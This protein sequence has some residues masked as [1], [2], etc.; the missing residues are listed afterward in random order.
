[1]PV[2]GN[3]SPIISR[4]SFTCR[5]ITNNPL[6]A[7]HYGHDHR[8]SDKAVYSCTLHNRRW[9]T[10]RRKRTS[11]NPAATHLRIHPLPSQRIPLRHFAHPPILLR[12]P[13]RPL[14]ARRPLPGQTPYHALDEQPGMQ[15]LAERPL[16]KGRR[17]RLP[18][19]IQH[20]LAPRVLA[21]CA[22]LLRQRRR[23]QLPPHRPRREKTRVRALR[24][25][26]LSA[27]A[28]MREE[29]REEEDMHVLPGGVLSVREGV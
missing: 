13:R 9:T 12:L 21:L 17:V 29:A 2:P 7:Y 25:R 10:T 18:A 15:A 19:R 23:L 3:H 26:L 5:S 16:Q 20:P 27:G 6:T 4:N 8:N 14:P 24:A 22:R 1:M 11:R 28:A